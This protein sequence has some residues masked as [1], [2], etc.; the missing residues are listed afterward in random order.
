MLLGAW[1]CAG[2]VATAQ[3]IVTDPVSSDARWTLEGS[4][5]VIEGN[6]VVQNGATLS[7]DPGVTVYMGANAGLS[8]QAGALRAQGSPS[9]P[10]RV[11]SNAARLGQTAAP[12]DWAQWTFGA[13]T[14]N[15]VLEHVE[16]EHGRGVVVNGS[17]PV[18]NNVTIRHHLGAAM[19]VDLAASPVGQGN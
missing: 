14:V 18:F 7:I 19:T 17:A 9:S 1:L 13:G 11:L 16:L 15:T 3:T 8:V 6:L 2:G 10:I 12:G 5:Y 4:P